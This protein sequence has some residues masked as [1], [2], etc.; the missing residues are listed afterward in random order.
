MH[1]ITILVVTWTDDLERE[2]LG[3]SLGETE[4]AKCWLNGK[5]NDI[6]RFLELGVSKTTIAKL[7][8]VSLLPTKAL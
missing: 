8:G 2:L 7:T 1:N 3:M 5:E 6:R 4:G